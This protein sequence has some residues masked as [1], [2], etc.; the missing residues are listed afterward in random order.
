VQ[1]FTRIRD[2]YE[3]GG[4]KFARRVARNLLRGVL[5]GISPNMVT[6][7]GCLLSGVAG[8]L[9]YN[10]AFLAAG[11]V[12]ILG[13]VLDA[14]DGAV[15]KV[16]GKVT[17]FGAFLDSTLDRVAEGLVLTALGLMF[18]RHDQTWAVLACFVALASSYLVS[19]TRAK[20]E[21]LDVQCKGGLASRVERVVLLSAGLL[22]AAFW[23]T[24]IEVVVYILAVLSALTVLQRVLNVRKALP[25]G[26]KPRKPPRPRRKGRRARLTTH[27]VTGDVTESDASGSTPGL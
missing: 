26:R 14:M 2:S 1:L 18:S 4:R 15:A 5:Q 8:V 27:P 12:F 17:A 16:T 10:E 19:Y 20:A 13:S 3:V 21:S 22:F 6:V 25:D 23:T 11:L 7:T 24:A 9:A